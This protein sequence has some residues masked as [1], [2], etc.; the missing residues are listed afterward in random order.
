M[1]LLRLEGRKM[2]PNPLAVP[3]H[4]LTNSTGYPIHY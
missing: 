3:I 1:G 2:A 4:R